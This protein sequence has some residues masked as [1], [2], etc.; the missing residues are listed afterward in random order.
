[1]GAAIQKGWP[2]ISKPVFA[3][4]LLLLSSLSMVMIDDQDWLESYD[5]VEFSQSNTGN[6]SPLWNQSFASLT[7]TEGSCWFSNHLAS[8]ETS[9]GYRCAN[10]EITNA[11]YSVVSEVPTSLPGK[12]SNVSSSYPSNTYHYVNDTVFY[13]AGNDVWKL[14]SD[15]SGWE[16]WSQLPSSF[17]NSYA[18]YHPIMVEE[19]TAVEDPNTGDLIVGSTTKVRSSSCSSSN[20]QCT[21]NRVHV[22]ITQDGLFN[23]TSGKQIYVQGSN[24]PSF[25]SLGVGADEQVLF[26]LGEQVVAGATHR[27]SN[28][29]WGYS[30]YYPNN[31]TEIHTNWNTN[32]DVPI[33]VRNG[34]EMRFYWWSTSRYSS[35]GATIVQ[36]LEMD[37]NLNVVEHTYSPQ[38]SMP[39]DNGFSIS[40]WWNIVPNLIP[41]VVN[42]NS[43]FHDLPGNQS[44]YIGSGSSGFFAHQNMVYELKNWGTGMQIIDADGDGYS[45]YRDAF[46]FDSTQNSDND[47]DGYGD[48]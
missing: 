24:C 35:N 1:M 5:F 20:C 4:L 18:Q 29:S 41:T 23:W 17:V 16:W 42:F 47:G 13:F 30:L 6:N 27:A 15:N 31:G 37:E 25:G 26:L 21:Y 10:Y 32:Q 44:I 19:I 28:G 3:V 34:D 39:Y 12:P 7:P 14:K 33:I 40:Q 9:R 36:L 8:Y 38:I 45:P 46:P 2:N 22:A 43:Y 11:S 48:N